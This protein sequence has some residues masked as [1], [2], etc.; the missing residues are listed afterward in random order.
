MTH[1]LRVLFSGSLLLVVK[2]V[3]AF[4][5]CEKR[6]WSRAVL[7]VFCPPTDIRT[8]TE[9]PLMG[10]GAGEGA[11]AREFL[12]MTFLLAVV[13]KSQLWLCEERG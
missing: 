1:N 7:S 8:L 10:Q 3:K 9:A 4:V 2:W 5:P 11:H 12:K 6:G 13:V